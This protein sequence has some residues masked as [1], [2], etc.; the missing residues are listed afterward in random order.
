MVKPFRKHKFKFRSEEKHI[1]NAAKEG[2]DAFRNLQER[3][4]KFKG[5]TFD[6]EDVKKATESLKELE[7]ALGHIKTLG[8]KQEHENIMMLASLENVIGGSEIHQLL[9]KEGRSISTSIKHKINEYLRTLRQQIW[10][11]KRVKRGKYPRDSII[12]QLFAKR[13][14]KKE[15]HQAS[16]A[17]EEGEEEKKLLKYIK[18]HTH[19]EDI[20]E[21]VQEFITL[22]EEHLETLH[23]IMH[24]SDV[25]EADAYRLIKTW[26]K[27]KL[28]KI[29]RKVN[30]GIKEMLKHE[31]K[32]LRYFYRFERKAAK[33]MKKAV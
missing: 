3:A 22:Y 25:Q 16:D 21:K 4:A 9:E 2:K 11:E 32:M 20:L 23:D 6:A 12:M 15:M 1:F 33:Q 30:P 10:D 8:M 31:I 13:L 7:K 19:D 26:N 28:K 17:R 24:E 5:S 18:K 27:G 14:G 29:Y